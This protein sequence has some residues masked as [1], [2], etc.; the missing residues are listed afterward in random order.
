MIYLTLNILTIEEEYSMLK[1]GSFSS[2]ASNIVSGDTNN[3][4]DVFVRGNSFP[5]LEQNPPVILVHGWQ[6]LA[7]FDENPNTNGYTCDGIAVVGIYTTLHVQNMDLTVG[8]TEI[9]I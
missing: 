5:H 4:N 1:S 7:L 2:E 8:I 3:K 6:G 9:V